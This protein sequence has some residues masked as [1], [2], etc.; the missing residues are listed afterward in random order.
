M[1]GE[2]LRLRLQP[3]A[4][5][6]CLDHEPHMRAGADVVEFVLDR[7]L[8][9][10]FS[11]LDRNDAHRDLDGHPHQGR[12]EMFYRHFHSNRILARIRVLQDQVAA[13]IFDVADHRR[14]RIGACLLAHE[15]D[16]AVRA[17]RDAIDAG[18]T[19]A[20]AWLHRSPPKER[21]AQGLKWVVA[22]G[23]SC[24]KGCAWRRP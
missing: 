19:R 20:K 3:L 16:G 1:R 7:D 12:R 22:A 9:R 15:A 5:F 11:S 10:D 2:P 6:G 4:R 8:E 21:L 24:G 23:A 17:D 14:R 13:R 18:G